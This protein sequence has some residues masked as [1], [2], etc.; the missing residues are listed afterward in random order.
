VRDDDE[1]AWE[2]SASASVG[3]ERRA[4][5]THAAGVRTGLIVSSTSSRHD[6]H[7]RAIAASCSASDGRTRR[8]ARPV[9]SRAS[10]G[11][12]DLRASNRGAAVE[13]QLA[14]VSV[15]VGLRASSR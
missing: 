6:E 7:V 10:I 13:Q 5:P 9:R 3:T 8:R 15:F 12:P 1:R 4:M 2:A 11:N 14:F